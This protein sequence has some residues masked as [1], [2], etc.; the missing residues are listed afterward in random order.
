MRVGKPMVRWF[1]PR[2]LLATGT[3]VVLSMVRSDFRVIEALEGEQQEYRYDDRDELWVDYV[4]D[5]GDGWNST[6]AMARLMAQDTLE[7]AGLDGALPHGDVLIMGGD[8]VYPMASREGYAEKLRAPYEAA[9]RGADPRDLYALPGNHDWYD[10]LSSFMRQFCQDRKLGA[11]TTRQRRSYFVLRLPN[12]WWLLAI[13][14]QLKADIDRPQMA[15]FAEHALGH[16]AEG[17]RVILCVAEPA[18]LHGLDSPECKN[19]RFI[20]TQIQAT[21]AEV[22]LW[23]AGDLHYYKRRAPTASPSK[24]TVHRVISGGGGAFLHP[25]HGVPTGE[26]TPAECAKSEACGASGECAQPDQCERKSKCYPTMETSRRL[27]LGNLAFCMRNP[28]FGT[29]FGAMYVVLGAAFFGLF[30][31]TQARV[32]SLGTALELGCAGLL[33]DPFALLWCLL[34]LGACISFTETGRWFGWISG[35]L[36]GAVHIVMAMLTAWLSV[37]AVGYV[38]DASFPKLVAG[39]VFIFV[40]GGGLGLGVVGVYLTLSSYFFGQVS[41]NAFAGMRIEGYKNFVRLHLRKDGGIDLH[42]VG[43]ERVPRA[44]REP[45]RNTGPRYEPLGEEP[46]QP[47]LIEVISLEP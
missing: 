39:S 46:A 3:H 26:A 16:M 14:M 34:L 18:W 8:Q 10:G 7:V 32:W 1:N 6:Y 27:S 12:D 33:Q 41:N 24:K 31:Q 44:W 5:L 43:L 20:E 35:V 40:V 21:G 42:A 22:R 29:V 38:F 28:R 19:L 25:T 30:E 11:L 37:A 4:A 45:S 17:S 9:F 13:D 36:L 23:L 2:Q 15:Y 47:H